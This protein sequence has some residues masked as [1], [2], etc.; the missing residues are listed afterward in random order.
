MME[1]TIFKGLSVTNFREITRLET[2]HGVNVEGAKFEA[3]GIDY[4]YFKSK[5]IVPLN[6]TDSDGMV[7]KEFSFFLIFE[8]SILEERINKIK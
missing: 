8:S 6:Y 7:E 5:I 4:I 2:L 1:K 3:N